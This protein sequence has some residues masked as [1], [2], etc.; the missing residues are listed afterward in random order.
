MIC[1]PF[2]SKESVIFGRFDQLTGLQRNHR[3]AAYEDNR[4]EDE[5]DRCEIADL[6][7]PEHEGHQSWHQNQ[8]W[9]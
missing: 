2:S 3:K 9:T 1:R 4:N 8:G 5:E 6:K 7:L